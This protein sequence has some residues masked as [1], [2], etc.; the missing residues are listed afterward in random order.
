MADEGPATSVKC[1]FC[2]EDIQASAKKCRHCG[3][4][5]D[6]AMREIELLK[7]Q[8]QN[9]FMNAGGGGGGGGGSS[10]SSAASAVGGFLGRMTCLDWI[11]TLCTGGLWLI[12][13]AL[14]GFL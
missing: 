7:S 13:V 12:V 14:R 3:E 9:V 1:P 8:K 6:P 4:F 11:L 10:A 5:V 2:S